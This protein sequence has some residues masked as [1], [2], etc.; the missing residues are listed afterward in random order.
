MKASVVRVYG[1]TLKQAAEA[2]LSAYDAVRK[3]EG[4]FKKEHKEALEA[5]EAFDGPY[6]EARSVVRAFVPH[7][8]LPDTL[9]AQPTDTNKLDAIE[10]L[11]DAIDDHSG[12]AWADEIAQGEIGQRAATTVKELNEAIASDKALAEA[13]DGRAA[14][15][16]PAYE[17]YLRY[18]RVVRDALGA[19]SRQYKRIHLRTTGD[20]DGPE[21]RP[22][23]PASNPPAAPREAAGPAS[24]R[25]S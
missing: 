19:K 12:E 9:K 24:S 2:F 13:R 22:E 6:R 4:G 5:L 23:K 10:K 21:T 18:K 14:A 16:G 8:S 3:A 25:A 11:L 7:T 1:E 17:R 20:E 15:Y